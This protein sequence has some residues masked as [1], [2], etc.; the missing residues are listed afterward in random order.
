M[1]D[2]N[3]FH[4]AEE[5]KSPPTTKRRNCLFVFSLQTGMHLMVCFDFITLI[6]LLSMYGT[7]YT[8]NSQELRKQM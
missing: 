1:S 6:M 2:D 3:K 5:L 7:A 8:D 4:R